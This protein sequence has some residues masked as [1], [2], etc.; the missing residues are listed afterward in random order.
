MSKMILGGSNLETFY[1]DK[2][3]KHL[4]PIEYLPDDYIGLN[5]GSITGLISECLAHDN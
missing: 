4:F 2:I 5:N 3:P 1:E